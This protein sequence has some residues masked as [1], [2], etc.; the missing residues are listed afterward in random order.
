MTSRALRLAGAACVVLAVVAAGYSGYRAS[1]DLAAGP[2][3]AAAD[4]PAP[5]DYDVAMAALVR[6]EE[7]K[8]AAVE[9]VAA[10]RLSLVEAAA[11]FRALEAGRPRNRYC[12]PAHELYPGDSEGERLCREVIAHVEAR[13]APQG[14]ARARQF[15][16]RLEAELGELLARDGTVRLPD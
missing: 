6:S 4:G 3:R 9:E 12:R 16:A 13:L 2:G 8:A 10:G 11:R 7:G 1:L 5:D 14:R 15:A